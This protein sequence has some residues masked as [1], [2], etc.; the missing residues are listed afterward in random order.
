[1]GN[2]L[3]GGRV[4]MEV[5]LFVRDGAIVPYYAGP[6]CNSFMDFSSIELHIL[7]RE[8]S[9]KFDYVLDDLKTRNYEAGLRSIAHVRGEVR[10]ICLH[11]EIFEDWS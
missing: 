2:W 7:C 9:A 10:G 1:M 11:V 3:Q 6:L 8:Q 5:P 4:L